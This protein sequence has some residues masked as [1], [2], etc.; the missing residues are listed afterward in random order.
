MVSNGP[1]QLVGLDRFLAGL[2]ARFVSL[3]AEAVDREILDALAQIGSFL[4]V[5][6][7]VMSEFAEDGETATVS[8]SWAAPGVEPIPTGVVMGP[9]LP[10]VF[11]TVRRGDV[12]QVPDTRA[13][14]PGWEVD[15]QEFR[16]SGARAHLSMRISVAGAPAR[17]QI[18]AA[19]ARLG[20]CETRDY[21]CAA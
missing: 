11:A 7:L 21:V 6:R 12:A 14:P 3:T 1:D 5:D 9:T 19:L 10:H 15:Q 16:R 4:D 18:R 8:H 2:S 20:F 13:L 17:E